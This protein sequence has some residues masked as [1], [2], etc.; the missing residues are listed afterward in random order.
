MNEFDH[1]MFDNI[2]DSKEKVCM[3]LLFLVKLQ[4]TYED[5]ADYF[6]DYKRQ[7]VKDKV[8]D[9]VKNLEAIIQSL[10]AQLKQKIAK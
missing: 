3:Q 6:K 8:N 7:E 9:T 1:G 10:N 2:P 5:L 4:M